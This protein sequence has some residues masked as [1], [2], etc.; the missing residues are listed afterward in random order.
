MANWRTDDPPEPDDAHTPRRA[1]Y[2][3]WYPGMSQPPWL[4]YRGRSLGR[5]EWLDVEEVTEGE[6]STVDGVTH[7]SPIDQPPLPDVDG[8]AN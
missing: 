5:D 4:A 1:V 2:W 3:V 6:H 7:W 8:R